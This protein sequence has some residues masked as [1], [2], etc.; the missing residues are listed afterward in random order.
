MSITFTINLN[1][2]PLTDNTIAFAN[3][4]AWNNYFN[5]LSADAEME[6]VVVTGYSDSPY[7][8]TLT[9]HSLTVDSTNYIFPTLD[10]FNSLKA[11]LQTLDASYQTMRQELYAAGL[12]SAP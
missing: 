7:D 12:I 9:P 11:Q 4:A 1:V 5:A 8:D 10:Q 6:P 2:T 3:A